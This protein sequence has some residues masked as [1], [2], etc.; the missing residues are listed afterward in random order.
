MTPSSAL[1]PGPM[2]EDPVTIFLISHGRPLYLWAC[3]DALWRQTRSAARVVLLDNAHPCPLV[4][5]VIEGYQRRGLLAEV[6]RFSTNS[7]ANIQTAYWERLPEVG[8]RHVY[9][10]SD[11]VI[12]ERQGCWLAEMGRI[13]RTHPEI[14]MLGSL[15]DPR[16]FVPRDTA[17]SLTGGDGAAATFLAKLQSPER[18]FLQAPEWADTSRDWFPTEPPCPIPNPPGRLL[19]LRTDA[20]RELGCL[21]DGQLAQ[22]FRQR[23]MRPSLTPLVRHRHLSLL[24]IY[25]YATYSG[26]ARDGYFFTNPAAR[27]PVPPSQREQ[28]GGL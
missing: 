15:I 4:G 22:G 11:V 14:G 17:L 6:V 8:E 20:M 12:Q 2:G 18:G 21:P 28:G 27:P 7:L 16:D 1:S 26:E 23:G 25:D 10:E 13:L 9:M 24:N 19:M 5:E 3:L